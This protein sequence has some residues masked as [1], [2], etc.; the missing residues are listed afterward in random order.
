MTGE[1]NGNDKQRRVGMTGR[2]IKERQ[3][4]K[5]TLIILTATGILLF[6][7]KASAAGFLLFGPRALA[8]GGAQ[9]AAADDATAIYWNPSAAACREE[10]NFVL[11]VGLRLIEHNDIIDRLQEISDIL[12]DYGFDD[13][14]IYL[15]PNK[16]N[17][18]LNIF[19]QLDEP[20][21]GLVGNGNIGLIFGKGNFSF[22]LVD[23]AYLG[24][25]V[26]MDLDRI[27]LAP[28]SFPNS[29]A[30][31]QSTVTALGLES[32]E[33]T[34]NYARGIGQILAGGNVKYIFGRTYYKSVS[35]ADENND[36]ESSFEKTSDSDFA[37]DAGFLYP[38][39][40]KK[41]K[42]GLVLRNINSP[43]FA[44]QDT[45]IKL[46]PQVRAG[47]VYEI[48]D[49]FVIAC[50]LDLTENE[51]MTPG[52]NDRTLGVGIEKKTQSEKF[53]FR[54]GLYKNVAESNA[55][56]VFTGGL[57]IGSEGFRFDIGAAINPGPDELALCFAFSSIF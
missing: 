34:V 38:S 51:T 46:K 4:T 22:G 49:N 31:N 1:G 24:G 19:R 15:D 27:E 40:E 13:P 30:N 6:A 52:Y 56:M 14:Q 42:A 29:I 55:N 3:M 48:K 10:N 43:S 33:V 54:G 20:G 7:C 53:A 37:I 28:P 8:M 36:V 18:L 32:R 16:I 45:E 26:D 47:V 44:Y 21:T 23:L 39:P 12:G 25:W 57:G 9:V 2:N 11:P 5:N 17:Q 50:D 35:V 41:W